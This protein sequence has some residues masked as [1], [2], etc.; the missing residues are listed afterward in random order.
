MTSPPQTIRIADRADPEAVRR[1][2]D[3]LYAFNVAATGIDDGRELFAELRDEGGVPYA[4][5]HGWSWGGTC[6]IELLWVRGDQRGQGVGTALM[7]AVETEARSR[8]CAQIALM[9]HSFQAPGFYRRQGFEP[10]GEVRDYPRRHSDL[11]LRRR[12]DS[13]G[14][15]D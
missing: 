8:G 5:V 11:L 6:W 1:L 9:T 2:T 7:E 12:L 14:G 10:V 3:A 13:A 15:G 4:G